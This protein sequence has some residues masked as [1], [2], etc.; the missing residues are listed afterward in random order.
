MHSSL[1]MAG[2]RTTE[3]QQVGGQLLPPR[4][5]PWP[6]RALGQYPSSA[7]VYS[8]CPWT[9]TLVS[10]SHLLSVLLVGHEPS[11]SLPP[12]SLL[13]LKQQAMVVLA[14][15]AATTILVIKPVSSIGMCAGVR[16]GSSAAHSG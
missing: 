16:L 4:L 12:I 1:R 8:L 6:R 11:H 7:P 14:E 3:A 9:A 15:A 13:G 5:A 2:W 10:P